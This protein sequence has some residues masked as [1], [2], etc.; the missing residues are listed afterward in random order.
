M[1]LSRSLARR[2]IAAGRRPGWLAAWLPVLFDTA[3]IIILYMLLWVSFRDWTIQFNFPVWASVAALFAL[4][5]IPLQGVVILSSLWA[6]RSRWVE[7][8]A[9]N[10]S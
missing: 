2:R 6:T 10:N 9:G 8:D 7:D 1:I 5:F 4:F 3:S